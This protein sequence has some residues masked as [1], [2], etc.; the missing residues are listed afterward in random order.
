MKKRALS[1]AK[2]KIKVLLLEGIHSSAVETF[3]RDGYT[4][5]EHYPK[6]LPEPELIA[7]ISRAYLIGIRSA[8]HLTARV[9]E[10]APKLISVGCFCIG[11]NQVDLETAQSRGVT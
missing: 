11:T 8:T 6:S 1:L 9:L 4:D 2:S 10:Q 5:V 7:A 3:H